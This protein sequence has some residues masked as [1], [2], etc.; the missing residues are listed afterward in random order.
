M[1]RY[2]VPADGQSH[3]VRL[4]GTPVAAA[5]TAAGSHGWAVEFWAEHTG[6]A[7]QIMR[8]FQVFGTGQ[9]LPEDARWISTSPGTGGIVWHL[10]EIGGGRP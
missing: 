5:V 9:P 3:V 8:R 6:G 7:M 10:Y 4:T 2:V 1:Y